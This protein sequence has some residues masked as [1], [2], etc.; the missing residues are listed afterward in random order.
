MSLRSSNRKK[1]QVNLRGG[2]RLQDAQELVSKNARKAARQMG[3]T[4]RQAKKIAAERMTT[5]RDWS[6]PRID[7]AGQYIEREVGPRVNELLH[8][9]A[10]K[11]EPAK[12]GRRRRGIGATLLLVGGTLGAAGAIAT[13]RNRAAGTKPETTPSTSADHLSA[14]SKNT[15]S[16]RAHTP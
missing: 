16:E 7:Q 13:R 9:T 10:E 8:R 14:V 1:P 6:A 4:S 5:A 3:P 11:V 15:S 2:S 12:P